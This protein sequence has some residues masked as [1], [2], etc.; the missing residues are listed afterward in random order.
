MSPVRSQPPGEHDLRRFLGPIPVAAHHLRAA[1]ADLA[2]RADRQRIAVIVADRDLGGGNRVADRA[3]EVGGARQVRRADRG[4]LGEAPALADV[5]P[6]DLAPALGYRRLHRHAAAQRDLQRA[7]V[8]PVEA[9][10]VEQRIEQ[11]VDAGDEGELHLREL[12][13]EARHVA[14][15]RDQH[16]VAADVGE[17]QHVRGER[18]DVVQRQRGDHRG[19]LELRELRHECDH[20]QGVR[21]HVPVRQ[22]RALGH[23]RRAAGVLQ[24]SDVL[25][26][27]LHRVERVR[28]ALRE[29]LGPA[30]R[31]RQRPGRHHLLH[32][33]DHE[34]RDRALRESRARRRCRSP[35]RGAARCARAPAASVAAAFSKITITVAPE[36]FSWCS[37]SRAV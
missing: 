22:H 25:A 27:D 2:D 5:P 28:A 37:S 10:R 29:H 20:L 16:V 36:S 30:D 26:A 18:E 23:A 7:E 6:G 14:W 11:R 19:I 12:L 34:V 8:E 9:G 3:R 24:E 31:V 4:R 33:T 21:D 17:H 1:D 35:R 32:A 15:V 13:H